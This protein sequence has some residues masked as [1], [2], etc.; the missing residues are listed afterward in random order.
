MRRPLGASALGPAFAIFALLLGCGGSQ[1]QTVPA[2]AGPLAPGL[3]RVWFYRVFLPDDTVGLPAIWMNGSPIGYAVSGTNFY[4]DVPAGGYHIAVASYG[5]DVNQA[6]D[7][8][9]PPGQQIYIK[10]DSLPSWENQGRD[11][12]ARHL[13]RPSGVAAARRAGIAADRVHKAPTEPFS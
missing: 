5:Q 10:I 4:R 6:Q 7:V 2:A 3:A 13:L 12:P 8:L 1:A 9:L 11:L